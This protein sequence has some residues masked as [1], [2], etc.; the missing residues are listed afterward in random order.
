M[1]NEFKDR[2]GE[3]FETMYQ[4]GIITGIGY[5]AIAV[6]V[7]LIIVAIVIEIIK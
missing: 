4:D 2:L 6:C 1:D 5:S 3:M 7:I